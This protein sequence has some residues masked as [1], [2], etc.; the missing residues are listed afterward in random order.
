M[1]Y[2]ASPGPPKDASMAAVRFSIGRKTWQQLLAESTA[3]CRY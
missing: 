2:P 1:S 3:V